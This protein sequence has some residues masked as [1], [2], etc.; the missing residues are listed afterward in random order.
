MIACQIDIVLVS[1]Q[2]ISKHQTGLHLFAFLICGLVEAGIFLDF[3]RF[4][5]GLRRRLSNGF[6]NIEVSV[7]SGRHLTL[8]PL[9]RA[10][11]IRRIIIHPAVCMNGTT[12]TR[13]F[14]S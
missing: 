14:L 9:P 11:I 4:L 7:K 10:K 2:N 5:E 6:I 3:S 13:A 8:S 12:H 1:R